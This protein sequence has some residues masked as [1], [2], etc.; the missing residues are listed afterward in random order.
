MIR[1]FPLHALLFLFIPSCNVTPTDTPMLLS[2]DGNWL[3]RADPGN[4]GTDERW[5][6]K[7]TDRSS[8]RDVRVPGSWE[9]YP[10]M[11]TYDGYGWFAREVDISET[12]KPLSLFFAGID[13]DATVWINGIEVG[14][15]EGHA[16]PF[17]VGAGDAVRPG[18]NWIV[19][20][21]LDHGGSGGIYGTIR[22]TTTDHVAA[23]LRGEFYGTDARESAEWVKKAVIY[24]VYL[25]SFSPEGTF[26]ALE[27]RL[28]ELRDLGATVLWLM[29]VHP[30]GTVK[31]KG[32]LGSP[33]SIADY[34]S[35]NPEFG[36]LDDFRSLVEATH[37]HGLKIIID[38]VANHTAW[39]NPLMR[40]NPG[41]YT[42]DSTGGIIPP[43][44]DWTD[45]ADLD[46]SNREMRE[47]MMEMMEYWVSDVGIDGF[48]CDVAEM[49]PT[50][51]WEEARRRL[52][53]IKPVMMLS[54]GSLPEHHRSAFD[55]TY[56]W[57]VYNA[58]SPLLGS[59]K[60]PA[61]LDDIL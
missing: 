29:P 59:V 32:S 55:I 52:D 16:E 4:R 15:H 37:R 31:R 40:T 53:A 46:Y 58:M 11:G 50:D 44:S 3:F 54:E 26:H 56:S 24:E 18:L 30:V 33:Y 7:T 60:P 8:W 35:V 25:R 43:N 22:I 41:W 39:D 42:T 49:V 2:I 6:E 27:H 21:V 61:L 20:R 57:G 10:D 1:G 51:F 47:W 19:I 48:R 45:V 17:A 38:L 14:N 12:G 13:D 36:S 28:P 34:Y 5:F 23:L 9:D